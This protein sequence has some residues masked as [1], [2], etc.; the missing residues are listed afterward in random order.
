MSRIRGD[1]NFPNT[2]ERGVAAPLDAT[3]YVPTLA[4]MLNHD[5]PAVLYKGIFVTVYNDPVEANNGTYVLKSN[6]G[7]NNIA[8]WARVADSDTIE[9]LVAQQVQSFI[10]TPV[11]TFVAGQDFSSLTG[12]Q[13]TVTEDLIPANHRN[14]LVYVNGS[15]RQL[16]AHYSINQNTITFA[17]SLSNA[18]VSVIWF[19]SEEDFTNRPPSANSNLVVN[20]RGTRSMQIGWVSGG[21]FSV[22][23]KATRYVLYYSLSQITQ[24][25]YKSARSK[26]INFDV[27][28]NNGD[29]MSAIVSGFE[30]RTTYFL[31]ITSERIDGN[32]VRESAISN[33]I[34]ATTKSEF[35]PV[36]NSTLLPVLPYNIIDWHRRFN[37]NPTTNAW[38]NTSKNAFDGDIVIDSLGNPS[39]DSSIGGFFQASSTGFRPWSNFR[40]LRLVADLAEPCR[41]DR[42][43]LH[44]GGL[45][46]DITLHVSLDGWNWSQF[47]T[48]DTVPWGDRNRFLRFD[49]P[50]SMRE[51]RYVMVMHQPGTINEVVIMGSRLSD[52]MPSGTKLLSQS[53]QLPINE[54]FA[55]N[56]FLNDWIE[57]WMKFGAINRIYSNW[58]W[59]IPQ[60][61]AFSPFMRLTPEDAALVPDGQ[62]VPITYLFEGNR[63]HGNTDARLTLV[64]QLNAQYYG[65]TET[66]AFLCVKS[67]IPALR[68]PLD[69]FDPNDPNLNFT[70]SSSSSWKAQDTA[71][72]P[73]YADT[74]DPMTYRFAAQCC[75]VFA[76]RYGRTTGHPVELLRVDSAE[77]PNQGMDLVKY[78][79]FWNEPNLTWEGERGFTNPFEFAAWMSAC[80]D[81][82]MGQLGPGMGM[83]AGDPTMLFVMPGLTGLYPDYMRG[84]MLWWD[85]HRGPGNYPIDVLSFHYYHNTVGGQG[86]SEGRAGLTPDMPSPNGEFFD[87][88]LPISREL[89]DRWFPG[90]EWWLSETGYDEGFRSLQAARIGDSVDNYPRPI[91]T[92]KGEWILKSMFHALGAGCQKIDHYMYRNGAPLAELN[93]NGFTNTY[94]SSGYVDITPDGPGRGLQPNPADFYPKLDSYF[95]IRAAMNALDG[96]KMSHRIQFRDLVEVDGVVV[97][98]PQDP[99]HDKIIA[100]AFTPAGPGTQTPCI[101]IWL[102]T[103]DDSETT[104]EMSVNEAFVDVVSIRNVAAQQVETG[105]LNVLT[106][107][108]DASRGTQFVTVPISETPT[109]VYTTNI[110][111]RPIQPAYLK[112][113]PSSDSSIRLYWDDFNPEHYQTRVFRL[114]PVSNEFELIFDGDA[115]NSRYDAVGLQAE[116]S[117]TF[118]IQFY[119][120]TTNRESLFSNS[121]TVRT[122]RLIVAP[123]N[124]QQLS[125]SFDRITL[126]WDYPVEEEVNITG[127]RIER[128]LQPTEGYSI[129]AT[130]G[131]D[132]RTHT[133]IGL[134][135]NTTYF[136]R[137]QAI[138]ASGASPRTGAVG[139]TT[140]EALLTPPVVN[141]AETDYFGNY[142]YLGFNIPVAQSANSASS[143]TVFDGTQFLTVEQTSVDQVG[144][145]LRLKLAQPVASN[146]VI[147]VGY[148]GSGF[149]T[150]LLDVP[151]EPFSNR[152]VLNNVEN[153]ALIGSRIGINITNSTNVLHEGTGWNNIVSPPT[154][155]SV[156]VGSVIDMITGDPT[157]YAFMM[158]LFTSTQR[159]NI[160]A[161]VNE[162]TRDFSSTDLSV[163]PL[164]AKK[165]L[166]NFNST[167]PTN[168]RMV[169]AFL[170][171]RNDR[172]YRIDV[173]SSRGSDATPR[174]T[175]FVLNENEST[176]QTLDVSNNADTIITFNGVT[177][178]TPP[179]QFSGDPTLYPLANMPKAT[180][181]LNIVGDRN[182]SGVN[183]LIMTEI[184]DPNFSEVV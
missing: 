139:I 38:H 111:Q 57:D 74:T 49:V 147:V 182:G 129:I 59:Y 107:Q 181:T 117:Y 172:L 54:A 123:T 98:D 34:Q 37:R 41:V 85:Y 146:A 64:K 82:H 140:S 25:N 112:A 16:G 122:N 96:L 131:P 35:A 42:V 132:A 73:D 36:P 128:S 84:A 105:Q 5:T 173:F 19:V 145:R 10:E 44:I 23:G 87:N 8:N 30:P 88:M 149:V 39:S 29:V 148:D 138:S 21:G 80:Y 170:N 97:L 142:V 169:C 58:S 46:N 108:A 69:G 157:E 75:F 159:R 161:I 77:T 52:S 89:R 76:A 124:L 55:S 12:D 120:I 154:D 100:Y 62:G 51:A 184:I 137:I 13:V 33:V 22:S 180:V 125:I 15:L 115:Q 31:A 11:R 18:S 6:T 90:K 24:Q 27:M 104:V 118:V 3:T 60:A 17:N 113:L 102:A 91:G 167:A 162:Q 28:G 165:A 68:L 103:T 143:F 92:L 119:D 7:K 175:T 155:Q 171:L 71:M 83:K 2:L 150:S 158:P 53:R 20:L 116:T 176:L 151:L 141:R 70:P 32:V 45:M 43:Y 110:R 153:S 61:T 183:A 134:L 114:D 72:Y 47:A 109:F 86:I 152:P 40:P 56:V 144:T 1:F 26:I 164:E 135:E 121:V 9:P 101:S 67:L 136:Y 94:Q 179:F 130:V 133:N 48:I 160:I 106:S 95:I 66:V 163:F 50:T 14:V 156:Y 79:Q 168:S 81:G 126:Q 127:F 174:E 4:N 78:F 65:I 177:A 63:V 99:L 166:M 93:A 178:A